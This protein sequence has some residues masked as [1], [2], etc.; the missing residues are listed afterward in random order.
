MPEIKKKKLLTIQP[1][2]WIL[3]TL[4]DE[5][6][7]DVKYIERKSTTSLIEM[8]FDVLWKAY[9]LEKGLFY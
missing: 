3:C 9:E 1:R 2:W 7:I 6:D 5:F 8:Y 4:C